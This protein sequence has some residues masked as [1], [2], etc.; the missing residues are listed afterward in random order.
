M[1]RGFSQSEIR[2]IYEQLRPEAAI[3][4]R[5]PWLLTLPLKF[6]DLNQN[7]DGIAY[8]DFGP[9]GKPYKRPSAIV[10]NEN[11]IHKM[12]E[13]EVRY[14]LGHELAHGSLSF[15]GNGPD[16]H[17]KHWLKRSAYLTGFGGSVLDLRADKE[18]FG[19]PEDYTLDVEN[20]F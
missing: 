13:D 8:T 2:A 5:A 4:F 14:T 20:K 19:Y 17:G 1:Q 18:M 15:I 16:G 11:I 10:F 3:V 12:D 6:A 9:L 7:I